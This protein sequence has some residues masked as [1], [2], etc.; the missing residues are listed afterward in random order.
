MKDVGFRLT[1]LKYSRNSLGGIHTS[2]NV[3]FRR[4]IA[5]PFASSLSVLLVSPMR[6][7]ASCGL[8]SLGWYLE[9]GIV[10]DDLKRSGIRPWGHSNPKLAATAYRCGSVLDVAR[11]KKARSFAAPG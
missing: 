7:F 8:D 4:R 1:D 2:G 3:P 10:P 6:R 11:Q 9:L 5:S